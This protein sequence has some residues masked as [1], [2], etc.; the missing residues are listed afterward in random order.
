MNSTFDLKTW[1]ID[2]DFNKIPWSIYLVRRSILRAVHENSHHARGVVVDLGCGEMPYRS[3]F[4]KPN[5]VQYIGIDVANNNY[6]TAVKPDLIW[7]GTEIPLETSSVDFLV[8]TEFLEHYYD[9]LHILREIR[10]VLKPDGKL[11]FTVPGIWPIHEPPY[12]YHRFTPFTLEK[13][14][15]MSGFGSSEIKP[16][17]GADYSFAIALALWFENRIGHRTRRVLK[18]FVGRFIKYII[19][20]DVPSSKF[21]SNQMYSGLYGVATPN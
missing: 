17:G 19:S 4:L 1:F 16:L 13:V 14:L 8:A 9:T 5:V 18:P 10:R 15:A 20:R 11:F 3:E 7:N 21:K 2:L 12:D 6:H